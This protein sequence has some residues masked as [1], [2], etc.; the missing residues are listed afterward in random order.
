M[1]NALAVILGLIAAILGVVLIVVWWS[2]FLIVLAGCLGVTLLFG[3]ALAL[4]IGISEMRASR[5]LEA[6]TESTS[7]PTTIEP[8]PSTEA[9][10]ETSKE[11]STGEDKPE[12]A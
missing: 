1:G 10:A 7:T 4:A 2:Q 5:E 11:E 9:A 8:A 6:A 3:G 12:S